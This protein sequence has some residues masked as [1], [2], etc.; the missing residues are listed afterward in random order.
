MK[1]R[2]LFLLEDLAVPITGGIIGAFIG[3]AI[4]RLLGIM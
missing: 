3:M 4:G 1:R 2:L